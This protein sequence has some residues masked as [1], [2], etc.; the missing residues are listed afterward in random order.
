MAFHFM[1]QK[2]GYDPN[3]GQTSS[4]EPILSSPTLQVYSSLLVGDLKTKK[5]GC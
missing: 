4:W 1:A 5:Q 2:N 3:H